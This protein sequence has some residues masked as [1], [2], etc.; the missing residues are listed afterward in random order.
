M[1]LSFF[2]EIKSLSQQQP[3]L[4]ESKQEKIAKFERELVE[5][6]KAIQG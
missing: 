3:K 2:E 1:D 6:E 4:K 5:F